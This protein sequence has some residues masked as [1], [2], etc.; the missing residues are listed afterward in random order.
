MRMRLA[1]N[2]FGGRA[3]G[4]VVDGDPRLLQS[5]SDVRL[6]HAEDGDFTGWICNEQVEE[7]VHGIFVAGLRN[8]GKTFAEKREQVRILDETKHDSI[9]AGDLLPFVVPG[10]GCGEHVFANARAS[11]RIFQ[12]LDK[13]YVAAVVR[14]RR[15]ERRE[16]VVPGG[17]GVGVGGDV[18]SSGAGSVDFR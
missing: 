11:D 15:N 5:E 14:P 10:V 4:I 6:R 7:S 8:L 2:P 13:L 16:L 18:S 9:W 3:F 1:E 17:V 12:S